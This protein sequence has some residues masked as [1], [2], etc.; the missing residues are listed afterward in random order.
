MEEKLTKVLP[1][2]TCS[3][4]G[5]KIELDPQYNRAYVLDVDAKSSAAK[6]FS[7]LKA[8][9]QA[10]HLSYIVKIARHRIL[11]KSEATTALSKL[12]N[13]GVCEFHIT[14]A[15]EPTLNARQRRHNT[16]EL[17][18]FDPRTKWTGNELPTNDLNC[19]HA[20]FSSTECI[21]VTD[22]C[23]QS[24]VDPDT[25]KLSLFQEVKDIKFEDI[26]NDDYPQLDIVTLQAIA[27][28]R[29][30]L[31]F[32]EDSILT[33]IMLTVIDS[34]TSQAITPVE[35]AL[36]K[37][38]RCKLKN[39]DTWSDWEAGERKQLNQF[40][41]LQMFGDDIER[42]LEENAIIL[43]SHWQ[44]H[45]KQDGQRRARQC[46]DGSKQVAPI[47][48]ALAK[49]YSSCVKHSIQQQFFVL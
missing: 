33:D 21:T 40:H 26:R 5:L 11:T 49:T 24:C 32:S 43:Q 42:P 9:Q 20:D 14:F 47:L 44:Y 28:L 1:M 31:D 46:Y 2:C 30:S 19:V 8:T 35:Q 34:I 12:R 3:N 16:N 36:G 45:V 37:F 41:D 22:H 7:S 15:I 25:V 10:I 18:L 27:A 13:E 6:L 39:M 38:T 48:H 29:S 17:A 23:T 4:F